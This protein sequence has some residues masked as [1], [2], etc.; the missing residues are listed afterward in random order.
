[1]KL[2]LLTRN[3]AVRQTIAAFSTMESDWNPSYFHDRLD[4]LR[5]L[6][7]REAIDVVVIDADFDLDAV[8]RIASWRACH[9]RSDYAILV[10]GQF[11]QRDAMAR[12]FAMGGDDIAVG[13]FHVEELHARTVHCVA[14]LR[15]QSRQVTHIEI[16]EYLLDRPS[17][18]A[19][20]RGQ[21]VGLTAREFALAWLFFSLPGAL[22]T[23]PRI[24]MDIWG[25][26]PEQVA[27]ALEQHIYK[28]RRKMCLDGEAGFKLKAVYGGGYRLDATLSARAADATLARAAEQGKSLL[29]LELAM[30]AV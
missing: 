24:A 11:P 15:E 4:L 12:A 7:S 27:R 6:A 8:S 13:P 18:T 29:G 9:A 25:Q 1:M 20:L 16:G 23:R 14:R 17:Q 10:I 22:L 19:L 5:H 30:Q 3:Q 28:V 2:A 26:P 21:N